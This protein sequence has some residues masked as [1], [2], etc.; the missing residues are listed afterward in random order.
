MKKPAP[1]IA[2]IGSG[3]GGIGMAIAL[4]RAG[5]DSFR[6][7]EKTGEVGGCWRDNTYPGAACDVPSHLYSYSFEPKTDWSRRFAPQAEI[8]G[9]L[10]HCAAKYD[11]RRHIQFNTEIAAAD[12]DAERGLWQ[13]TTT[14]GERSEAQIL[15]SACGQLNRPATPK[16]PGIENFRGHSFHSA[17]WDHDHDLGGKRVAVIGT[18][19]SAIQFVPEIAPKVAQLTLFQRSAPYVIPKPDREYPNS[20]QNLLSRL[21]L[22]QRLSRWAK[23]WH[24]EG[25]AIGFVTAPKLLRLYARAFR[26]H[27]RQQVPEAELRA[28]LMPDYPMGC[29]RILISNNYYPALRRDNVEV[30]NDGIAEIEANAIRLRDGRRIEIDTLI[31]GTGFAATDFLAPM[32]ISGLDGLDL[33]TAWRDGAEAYL[34]VTVSG[35]PNLFMLYGPNTNLGH[36][37]IVFMLESQVRYIMS[38]IGELRRK[39]KRW[40]DVRA[41]VQHRFNARLQDQAER[42]IWNQGCNS[43]YKTESGRNTNNWTGY[44]LSYRQATRRLRP[45]DYAFNKI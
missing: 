22:L 23:Y 13:I 39:D 44:T 36:N 24:H 11:I 38:A 2:I 1:S 27:L 16:L 42:T 45:G 3:F 30:I 28:K 19:A 41:D 17:R 7:F 10:R 5:I 31:Y 34:G 18:G 43:W 21:P 9:Y 14:D 35:F 20:E 12:F 8:L 32:R 25:R 4:R 26:R 15:I 29:K 6:I 33:N 37:S 40:L